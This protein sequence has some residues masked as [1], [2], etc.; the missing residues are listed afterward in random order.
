ML[1]WLVNVP[2]LMWMALLSTTVSCYLLPQKSC[3]ACS[4]C[5]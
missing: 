2:P 1:S 5:D 3:G 4:M